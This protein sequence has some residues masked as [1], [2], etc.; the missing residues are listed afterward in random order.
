MSSEPLE[1]VHSIAIST[2]TSLSVV[3]NRL[4][5]FPAIKDSKVLFLS[6][7]LLKLIASYLKTHV[8]EQ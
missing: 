4:L 3:S 8:I 5:T 6:F 2:F 1:P 7:H